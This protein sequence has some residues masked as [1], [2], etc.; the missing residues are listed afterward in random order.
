MKFNSSAYIDS[1]THC[2]HLPLSQFK[3]E[4]TSFKITLDCW[5]STCEDVQS[6]IDYNK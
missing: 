3:L 5:P 4:D 6:N 1:D 2:Y